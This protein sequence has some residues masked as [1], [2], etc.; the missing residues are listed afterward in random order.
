M[1]LKH[2]QIFTAVYEETSIT[3]AA[4]R[5]KITQPAASLAIKELE[6]YYHIRLFDRNRRGIEPTPAGEH[7]YSAASQLLSLYTKMDQDMKTWDTSGILRIGSSTSIGTSI[8]PDV[9]HDFA[10]QFPHLSL[11]VH[12]DSSENITQK[13]LDKQLDL[14]LIDG[15]IPSGSF[16]TKTFLT[17]ELIPICSTSHPFA[18]ATDVSLKELEQEHFLMREKQSGTR[19]VLDA[20]FA[21]KRFQPKTILESTSSTSLI[22][23]VAAELGIAILPKSTLEKPLR[24]HQVA[25]FVIEELTLQ[26]HYHLIYPKKKEVSLPMQKFFELFLHS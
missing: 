26:Y 2:I 19:Q 15:N 17:E 6:E 7:L 14:A 5:L 20:F 12:I 9:L 22:H 18:N 8:L 21:S 24:T 13:L 4:Q 23:A 1:T 10:G 11:S 16:Q 3:L 25:S